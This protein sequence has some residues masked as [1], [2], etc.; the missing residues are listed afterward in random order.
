M[1]QRCW[2]LPRNFI[3]TKLPDCSRWLEGK[4]ETFSPNVHWEFDENPGQKVSGSLNVTRRKKKSSQFQLLTKSE[5]ENP[6]AM[7]LVHKQ[8]QHW[9]RMDFLIQLPIIFGCIIRLDYDRGEGSKIQVIVFPR[10]WNA[11]LLELSYMNTLRDAVNSCPVP[12][13]VNL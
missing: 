3:L 6:V 5:K 12:G 11:P 4:G 9:V 10:A 7:L 2:P 13:L 1:W 8:T